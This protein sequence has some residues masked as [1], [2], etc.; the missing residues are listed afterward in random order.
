MRRRYLHNN[1][2][3]LLLAVMFVVVGAGTAL[4]TTS[5][6]PRFELSEPEFGAGSSL[7]TCSG[8][9]CAQA[10]IGDIGGGISAGGTSSATF[11]GGL[12]AVEEP[13]L[14]V[15]VE[16]GV[17]NLGVL[18]TD[19]TAHRE[20]VVKIRTYL[21]D[22]YIMQIVGDPPRYGNHTLATPSSPVASA[23]GTEQFAM[24]VVANTAPSVGANPEQ[25][26]SSEMSFGYVMPNY[27]TAN[28]FMYQSGAVVAR[29]DTESGQTNYTITM[30]VNVA[31]ST[32]AGHF[33]GDYAA[34]VT[35]RF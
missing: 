35:P 11:T 7:E 22:G 6:S 31:G 8:R 23:A 4:A 20:L 26:P 14:E 12:G 2:K 21:S 13:L 33:S 10:S 15:I 19:S 28:R 27:E 30:I 5:Q 18:R 29:S 24:N 1:A 34:V 25:F 32:P 9:Y 16:P 17:S 3:A